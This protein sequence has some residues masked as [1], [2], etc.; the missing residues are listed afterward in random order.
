MK[1]NNE[2]KNSKKYLNGEKEPNINL[3]I[4]SVIRYIKKIIVKDLNEVEEN[5]N[6]KYSKISHLERES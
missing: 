5:L 6:L 3:E 4:K 1:Q 2:L